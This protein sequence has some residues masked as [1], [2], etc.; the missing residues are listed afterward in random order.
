MQIDIKEYLLNYI[1]DISWYGET[2]HDN[3]AADNMTKADKVLE[4]LEDIQSTIISELDDHQMYRKGNASA[5]MLH[6]KAG[7]ILKNHRCYQDWPSITEE[8][9]KEYWDGE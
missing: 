7:H 4:L 2:N 9:F 3:R 6:I 5:E 8:D 1:G